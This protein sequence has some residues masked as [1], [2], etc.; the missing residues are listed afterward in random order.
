MPGHEVRTFGFDV[1]DD[2]DSPGIGLELTTD[3]IDDTAF[4]PELPVEE[5]LGRLRKLAEELR[6]RRSADMTGDMDMLLS[7]VKRCIRQLRSSPVDGEATLDAVGMD[8][9]DRMDDDDPADHFEDDEV[10]THDLETRRI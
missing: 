9:T 1:G 4:S 5:R 10:D 2:D 7:H 6:I 8:T 3:D